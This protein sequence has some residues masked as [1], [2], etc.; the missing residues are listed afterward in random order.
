MTLGAAGASYR[1]PMDVR[2]MWSRYGDV[3]LAVGIAIL[4]TV[5]ITAWKDSD[6]ALSIPLAVLTGGLFLLRRRAPLVTFLLVSLANDG[7]LL[8][9]PGFDANS[10]SFVVVFVLNLYSLGRHATGLEA[11][12][13]ILGVLGTVVFFVVGDGAHD[14]ADIF[15]GLVFVGAPWATGLTLRLRGERETV[16]NARNEE[17]RAEQAELARRAVTEERARIAREL[18]DVVSHAISVTVL[19]ARGA[20]RMIGSD[21]DAIRTAL[22]AIEQTNTAALGDMRRLLAVLR[23]TD[24]NDATRAAP[25]P[26]LASLEV[27]LD[28]VRGSGLAVDLEVS[29]EPGPIPPGVDLSAYRIIQE[30]LT[31][32]LKHAGPEASA[33]VHLR[34]GADDIDLAIDSTGATRVNGDGSGHGLVG[35]RER[36]SVVGGTVDAGPGQD[37]GYLVH[38]HLPFSVDA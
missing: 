1:V 36:V 12:L 6:H 3:L 16:L 17:L 33:T 4:Y 22:D 28:H 21:D 2:A 10:V 31:N 34:Y 37:G 9:P 14:A 23:D 13:G 24:S 11:W 15:F 5:E 18:H 20:R 29:G 26:S 19:Q 38:A 27:L 8:V 35:I 7:V 25:Q 30:A 32:V